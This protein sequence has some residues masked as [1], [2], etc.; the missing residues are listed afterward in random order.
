VK[1]AVTPLF[2]NIREQIEAT[3]RMMA[4]VGYRPAAPSDGF[5]HITVPVEEL[6]LDQEAAAYATRWWDEEDAFT[7]NIGCCNYPTRPATI[8]AV[9]A[10]RLM[11]SGVFGDPWALK[12]MRL[13]VAELEAQPEPPRLS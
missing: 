10:A 1:R 12:L 6:D 5:G 2:T 9:E 8:Y 4:E 13:A 7:F 3:Y 11:G